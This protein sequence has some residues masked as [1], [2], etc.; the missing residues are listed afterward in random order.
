MSDKIRV[1]VA[2]LKRLHDGDADYEGALSM[3]R[4]LQTTTRTQISRLEEMHGHSEVL[5]TLLEHAPAV[6]ASLSS[7]QIN[8]LGDAQRLEIIA[9]RRALQMAESLLRQ[10][11]TRQA[12]AYDQDVVYQSM[13]NLLELC[14]L[15]K[16]NQPPSN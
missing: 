10:A 6:S 7:A 4:G 5:A 14:M 8:N 15:I 9:T 2:T 11:L 12:R 3:Y 13:Q 16:R 1:A